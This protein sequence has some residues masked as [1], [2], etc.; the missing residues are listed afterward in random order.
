MTRASLILDQNGIKTHTPEKTP[1]GLPFFRK[2]AT[3]QDQNE[4]RI[5]SCIQ[6]S[7]LPKGNIVDIYRVDNLYYEM[8]LL[9][10]QYWDEADKQRDIW[11]ALKQLHSMHIVYVDIKEDNVG[12]SHKDRTWKVFDFDCSGMVNETDCRRW[13]IEPPFYYNYKLA[14]KLLSKSSKHVDDIQLED[15]EPEDVRQIDEVLYAFK[16]S[17]STPPNASI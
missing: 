12:F 17:T 8:E 14:W 3:P 16:M 15:H 6:A 4:L 5:V 10:C 9:D 11:N 13:K 1:G 2:Y 7:S